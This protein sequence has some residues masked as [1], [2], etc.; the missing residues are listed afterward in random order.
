MPP[1]ELRE[2]AAA[3]PGLARAVLRFNLLPVSYIHPDRLTAREQEMGLA[4]GTWQRLLQCERLAGRLSRRLLERFGLAGLWCWDFTLPLRRL[5]LLPLD[6][7]LRIARFTGAFLHAG[8]IRTVIAR[9]PHE[10]LRR[11]IGEEGHA[12]ALK[13]APFLRRPPERARPAD[14]PAAIRRD[15]ESCLA[16][17]LAAEP[18]SVSARVRLRFPPG[19]GIDEPDHELAGAAGREALLT[20]LRAGDPAWRAYCG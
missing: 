6:E 19:G 17:W 2:L 10:A 14:L 16:G 15:G 12:F 20:V 18:P 13:R 7:L 5:A 8:T 4:A 3:D 1:A 9:A 11:E